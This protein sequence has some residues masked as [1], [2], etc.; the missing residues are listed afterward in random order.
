M[1]YPEYTYVKSVYLCLVI[2]GDITNASK[3][4]S[5]EATASKLEASVGN[6]LLLSKNTSH[7]SLIESS[8][9]SH[10]MSETKESEGILDKVI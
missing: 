1:H 5:L 3:P 6:F 10:C 9:I 2:S 8:G 4:V 7:L